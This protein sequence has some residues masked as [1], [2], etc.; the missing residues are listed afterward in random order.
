MKLGL[1]RLRSESFIYLIIFLSI[2]LSLSLF[3]SRLFILTDA[4]FEFINIRWEFSVALWSLK[5]SPVCYC[6]CFNINWYSLKICRRTDRQTDCLPACLVGF[7]ASGFC[8]SSFRL[9]EITSRVSTLSGQGPYNSVMWHGRWHR[10]RS[11]QY[12]N[13]P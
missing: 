9:P 1:R 10:Q 3:P 4:V 7:L 13:K 11:K 12:V 5:V 6:Y 2:Y 8:L